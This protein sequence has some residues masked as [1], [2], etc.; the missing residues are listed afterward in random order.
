MDERIKLTE[1][2]IGVFDRIHL[3]IDVKGVE[4]FEQLKQ[5]ILD[6]QE[7]AEQRDKVVAKLAELETTFPEVLEKAKKLDSYH[8]EKQVDKLQVE[9]KQLK[10]DLRHSM[11]QT[12]RSLS[13]AEKREKI[14]EKI[15]EAWKNREFSSEGDDFGD[16]LTEIL[17][18]INND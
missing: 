8:Y 3:V 13:L 7:K 10:Q 6:D 1:D 12:E 14:V 15:K 17:K 18:G 4:E 5:Q 11:N 16:E 9:N 2:D